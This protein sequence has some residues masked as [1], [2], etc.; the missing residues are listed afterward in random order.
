MCAKTTILSLLLASTTSATSLG[1]L[2]R[3]NR[4][5]PAILD[6]I[7]VTSTVSVAAPTVTVTATPSTLLDTVATPLAA[8]LSDE[9]ATDIVISW[10][11]I[12]TQT[13]R[14]VANETAQKLIANEFLGTSNSIN[15]L[16][17][18]EVSTLPHGLSFD[19]KHLGSF[20]GS[21][22]LPLIVTVSW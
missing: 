9:Q 14:S 1:L 12:L 21:I 6:T 11:T 17:G 7:T 5:C 19:L 16:S 8:C 13:D 10:K 4:L 18:L 3:A 15:S 22:G 2:G 20:T